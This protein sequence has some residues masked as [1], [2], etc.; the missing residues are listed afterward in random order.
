MSVEE[1]NPNGDAAALRYGPSGSIVP[2]K[3]ADG[4]IRLVW[5]LLAPFMGLAIVLAFFQYKSPATFLRPL[6]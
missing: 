1:D 6:A 3:S 5:K 4:W 2:H